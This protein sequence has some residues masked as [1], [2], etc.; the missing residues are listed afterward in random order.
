MW[1]KKLSNYEKL[2]LRSGCGMDIVCKPR[3][4]NEDAKL[5]RHA[6]AS[7][8]INVLLGSAYSIERVPTLGH[9]ESWFCG[10]EKKLQ[11]EAT[12]NE[13]KWA[14]ALLKAEY[15]LSVMYPLVGVGPSDNQVQLADVLVGL[16]RDRGAAVAPRR[17]NVFT[18][19]YDPLFELAL[20]KNHVTYNDG[21][22]GRNEPEYDASTFSRLQYEQSLFMEYSAQ[23]PTVNVLKPHGSLTW[24]RKGDR[25]VYSK[26]DDTLRD[27]IKGC[28]RIEGSPAIA[29]LKKLLG[30]ECNESGLKALQNL[31]AGLSASEATTLKRF[32]N[33]YDTTLCVVNPSKRKFE[34]TL[35]EQSYY[36]LLRI[37]ANELD[38]NNALLLV[39]GFS[40][41]DEHIR[42]LT[43]RAAKSNPKLLIV[44]SCYSANDR[45][46]IG[47]YFKECD[48]VWYIEPSEGEHIQLKNFTEGLK[49]IV[50]Q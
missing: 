33:Q 13:W 39:F 6:L 9:R 14:Y 27:C 19:N 45:S 3:I 7:A 16:V 49:C 15:F 32:A 29:S 26:A 47:A 24:K 44:I 41:A 31:A 2:L 8:H 1:V 36:D 12:N 50:R 21:F 28:K 17:L 30:L 38:R 40:F 43:V 37:Y 10:V 5:L 48:N 23:V 18:T 4:D 35:L 11:E 46:K 20:E 25:V 42:D 22:V 34:E